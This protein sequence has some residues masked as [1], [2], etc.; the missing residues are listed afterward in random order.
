MDTD[1]FVS[2]KV[3]CGVVSEGLIN[4]L[5]KILLKNE[6]KSSIK[7]IKRP[8]NRKDLY[9]LTIDKSYLNSYY[10]KIGFSNLRKEK[11]LLTLL[12]K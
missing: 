11:E 2:N 8:P 12:K 9:L 4:N 10:E 1:G 7:I 5:K 6:I 3:G